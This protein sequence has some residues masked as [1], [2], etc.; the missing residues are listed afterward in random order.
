MGCVYLVQI[1]PIAWNAKPIHDGVLFVKVDTML[2]EGSVT[3]AHGWRDVRRVD[4]TK[5]HVQDV[6]QSTIFN[7][8]DVLSVF[9]DV[10]I[11]QISIVVMFA[12]IS[13]TF[14]LF[15]ARTLLNLCC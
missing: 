5:R 15:T 13:I 9:K 8:T 11:V 4:N 1:Y 10:I 3:S 2:V 7:P 12:L 14:S 6:F